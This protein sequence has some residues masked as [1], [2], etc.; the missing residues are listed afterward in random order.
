MGKITY[1]SSQNQNFYIAINP[2]TE[3]TEGG[4]VWF[5]SSENERD[6][7]FPNRLIDL[8]KNASSTHTAFINLKSNLTFGDGLE[9]AQKDDLQI[10]DFLKRT[11]RSGQNMNDI[12]KRMSFDFSLQGAAALQV[13]YDSEG[14]VAEVYHTCPSKLRASPANEFGYS[15]FWYWSNSWGIVQNKRRNKPQN[16]LSNAVCIPNFNPEKGKEDGRQIL[17]LKNAIS[18]EDTYGIPSYNAGLYWVNID[19]ELAKFH[20]NKIMNG[21][22]PTSLITLYGNPADEEKDAFVKDFK[23]N[24]LGTDNTGNPLFIWIDDQTQ[25]PLVERLEGDTNEG[26]YEE[27]NKICVEKIAT[28]HGGSLELVGIN[29]GGVSLGGDA[30]KL[31]VARSTYIISIIKPMQEVLIDGI[32]KLLKVNGY[33]GEVTVT[34]SPLRLT[35]PVAGPDDLTIDERRKILY[36]LPP[37]NSAV[38]NTVPS[39]SGSTIAGEVPVS[40]STTAVPVV[41]NDKLAGLSG[42]EFINMMRYVRQIKNKKMNKDAGILILKASYGLDDTT[43]NAL[44]TDEEADDAVV[45]NNN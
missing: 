37:I 31:N 45:L 13:I 38:S 34:N 30:N 18:G 7:A 22:T 9:P 6:N 35:Q 16:Q 28:S 4:Y 10:E 3:V 12:Y 2:N 32:N 21:F 23:R 8:Y 39:A 14:R 20:L 43:I 27:L 40:A 1:K 44:I 26:A 29:E 19:F 24:H 5:N 15:D 36:D 17:Y 42:K 33:V 25:K 41:T 11:N